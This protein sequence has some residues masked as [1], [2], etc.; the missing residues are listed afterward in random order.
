MN[1]G[2]RAAVLRRSERTRVLS[3][4]DDEV[5]GFRARS[6]ASGASNEHGH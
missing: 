3:A 1:P 2:S 4:R 5:G 6:A